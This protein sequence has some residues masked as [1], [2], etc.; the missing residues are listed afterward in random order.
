V[1]SQTCSV[2]C[3]CV[4]CFVLCV[5]GVVCCS[6]HSTGSLTHLQRTQHW[7]CVFL[8]LCVAGVVSCSVHSTVARDLELGA[9]RQRGLYRQ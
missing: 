1:V 9:E 3:C 6:A 7:F 5:A 4:V 2:R 8:V